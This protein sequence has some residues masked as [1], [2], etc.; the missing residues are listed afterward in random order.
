MKSFREFLYES[1]KSDEYEHSLAKYINT[2][3]E[4]YGLS[5]VRPA[6]STSYSDILLTR[7]GKQC[8]LEVK[9]NHTDNLSNIR[10]FYREG[11]WQST[12]NGSVAK[13]ITE[14]LNKSED[15]KQFVKD[16]SE[17]SGI[18]LNSIYIPTT[19]GGLSDSNA[20]P[21]DVMKKF[22]DSYKTKRYIIKQDNYNITELVTELVM[23]HYLNGKIEPAY[24]IQ[25]GDDFF[26]LTQR[27]PLG[28]N[29]N[30]PKFNGVG[31]FNVRVST[32]SAF[33]EIQPEIKV[34]NIS[35]DSEFSFKPNS[36][37]KLPF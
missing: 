28:F 35:R 17:F 29:R 7:N 23:V 2:V 15:A 10:V 8:W 31:I 20:V 21:L 11:K 25:T 37:K 26:R 14:V 18:P 1:K 5:C 34:K 33:Y 4:P 13:K 27:N 3:G 6:V 24:Y 30:V 16:L 19:K 36:K 22:C 9:M 32:R 12:N